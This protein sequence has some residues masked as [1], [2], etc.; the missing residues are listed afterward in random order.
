[1]KWIFGSMIDS[2]KDGEYELLSCEMIS[3]NKARLN[4]AVFS[5][6][7]GG[8]DCMKALIESFDFEITE[9]CD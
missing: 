2:F 1:M 4:F 7:Y 9:I 3:D 6:P 5:D 8:T